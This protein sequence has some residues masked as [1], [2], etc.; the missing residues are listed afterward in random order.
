MN[1]SYFRNF[2][3]FIIAIIP[4]LSYIFSAG[5][6]QS[7]GNENFQHNSDITALDT[8][9]NAAYLN[10]L[11][12]AIILEMNKVRTNPPKYAEIN[13]KP[14]L[15]RFSGNK[16]L[17]LGKTYA[18]KEGKSAVEECYKVLNKTKTAGLLY[19]DGNLTKAA[20]DHVKDQERTADIGHS[21]NDGSTPLMRVK[22][23]VNSDYIF[24]GE[25]ISYGLTSADEIVS[26]LLINDGMPSRGHRE[27]LLNPRFNLAGVSCGYHKVY[28][29]MCVIMYGTFQR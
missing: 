10:N 14:M 27:I 7:A 28:K 12:K 3:I 15:K 4:F 9:F 20:R 23:Y 5:D 17:H 11:E 26:F 16:Y 2:H 21:G 19:P 22:K 24:I 8:T 29:T 13:I 25:N 1:K 6:L 18:T